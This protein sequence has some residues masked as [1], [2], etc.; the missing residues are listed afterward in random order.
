M[1]KQKLGSGHSGQ[2]L[3]VDSWAGRGSMAGKKGS[4][5]TMLREM[6]TRCPLSVSIFGAEIKVVEFEI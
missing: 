4:S 5:S 1:K 2:R 6:I 3:W